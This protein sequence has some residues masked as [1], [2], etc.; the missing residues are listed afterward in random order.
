[1]ARIWASESGSVTGVRRLRTNECTHRGGGA[2]G[3][4]PGANA[5]EQGGVQ[6]SC[7]GR[8]IPA[9]AHHKR[10]RRKRNDEQRCSDQFHASS[11]AGA[12]ELRPQDWP[13]DGRED[14]R[15]RRGYGCRSDLHWGGV[16]RMVGATIMP[17][18]ACSQGPTGAVLAAHG[19]SEP[20]VAHAPPISGQVIELVQPVEMVDGNL[21]NGFRLG[22]AP[23]DGDPAAS[24]LI[25][26][27]RAPVRNAGT[28]GAEVKL[29]GF[30]T[31]A[32]PRRARNGD[33]PTTRRNDGRLK[34]G[35][36]L[37]AAHV[38]R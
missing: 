12:A 34:L 38:K 11:G 10:V 14:A 4:Q 26:R 25:R 7:S 3:K 2:G 27:L 13:D 29:H 5:L 23:V 15:K 24:I 30:P 18:E 28:S 35:R 8:L 31:D 20:V 21:G 36:P 37:C 32:G 6:R 19:K 33:R 22:Q 17:S 9:E 16:C 1:M